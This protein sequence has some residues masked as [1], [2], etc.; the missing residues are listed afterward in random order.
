MYW[1]ADLNP[2]SKG[3]QNVWQRR[4]KTTL[5]KQFAEK[6]AECIHPGQ[7][8]K[9]LE[10]PSSLTSKCQLLEK[11]YFTGKPNVV[12]RGKKETWTIMFIHEWSSSIKLRKLPIFIPLEIITLSIVTT[13]P[14]GSFA[15]QSQSKTIKI[16]TS[17]F[18]SSW[19]RTPTAWQYL[20]NECSNNEKYQYSRRKEK[21][22][23]S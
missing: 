8:N 3:Q 16:I 2:S 17:K 4:T 20:R 14:H 5:K 13:D 22:R 1:W 18:F 12:Q 21:E 7:S 11:D 19:C 9:N 15:M 10:Q 23:E 6:L